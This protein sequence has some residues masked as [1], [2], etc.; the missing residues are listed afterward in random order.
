MRSAALKPALRLVKPSANQETVEHLETMLA[1]A[2]NGEITGL[3]YVITLP[4]MRFITNMTGICFDHPTFARG[5]VAFLNDQ[6]AGL[7]HD[8]DAQDVR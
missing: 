2:K 3:A 6:L 8:R 7:V 1:A 5:A 4:G